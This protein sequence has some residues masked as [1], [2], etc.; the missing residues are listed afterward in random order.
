M[1]AAPRV[2]GRSIDQS[3]NTL[4]ESPKTSNLRFFAVAQLIALVSLL[5]VPFA[6]VKGIA[7]EDSFIGMFQGMI[8]TDDSWDS[9]YVYLNENVALEDFLPM[10]MYRIWL[11]FSVVIFFLAWLVKSETVQ[12]MRKA[13]FTVLTILILGY[14]L[15]LVILVINYEDFYV[16]DRSIRD[17]VIVVRL[18]F[19]F[20]SLL[21]L[22][23]IFSL[24]VFTSILNT[25][26]AE[27]E[28]LKEQEQMD[29]ELDDLRTQVDLRKCAFLDEE[30]VAGSCE[31]SVEYAAKATIMG[32]SG[33]P[34]GIKHAR[35]CA[36]HA[37]GISK[38]L[39]PSIVEK[40]SAIELA[41]LQY[42][43][44]PHKCA[45][46]DAQTPFG[47]CE[48]EVEYMAKVTT[49]LGSGK[50]NSIK[51]GRYCMMHAKKISKS[52]SPSLLE[53]L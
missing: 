26:F 7:R 17:T 31:R 29:E 41:E 1:T 24:V 12:A 34:L 37:R 2:S 8:A 23:H 53:E 45:V 14:L 20:G 38:T 10:Q 16:V 15:Y 50:P 51:G 42:V 4:Y 47:S 25:Y 40:L 35:Y 19:H 46:D 18:A 44:D 5:F 3:L 21:L 52:L 6:R 39:A 13:I 33:H 27:I 11:I 32:S 49:L 43:I 22:F 30:G 48:R 28:S 36:V 9:I